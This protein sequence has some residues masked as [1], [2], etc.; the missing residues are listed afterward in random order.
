M[1]TLILVL[2][3]ISAAHGATL[4]M[5]FEEAGA[6]YD[7]APELLEAISMV[8]SNKNPLAMTKNTNGTLDLGHMQINSFWRSRLNDHYKQLLSPCY[9]TRVG[10][11]ILRDCMARYG[12]SWYAVACYHAGPLTS[13]R[14]I[15]RG[16]N[17]VEKI[18]QA[19]HKKGI[20]K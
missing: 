1:R 20:R 17:Y 14:K 8:E 10:A 19:L 2:I 12:Y 3:M 9:C 5:C 16:S 13:Q 11:W 18:K 6:E 15:R 4:D 7:I